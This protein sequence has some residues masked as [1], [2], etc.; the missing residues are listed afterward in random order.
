M[1]TLVSTAEGLVPLDELSALQLRVARRADQLV[2]TS[3]YGTASNFHC[4]FLAEA[5]IWKAMGREIALAG[6]GS[7]ALDEAA[8]A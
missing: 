1:N 3:S 8:A 7:L 4:W 2:T 5:E 6:S